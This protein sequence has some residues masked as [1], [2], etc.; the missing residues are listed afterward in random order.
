MGTTEPRVAVYGR[1]EDGH[2]VNLGD[3]PTSTYRIDAQKLLNKFMG[4]DPPPEP[5]KAEVKE[6]KT[7]E[8]KPKAKSRG[9]YKKK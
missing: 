4:L 9:K 1:D 2:R 8:S 3:V 7:K 6:S 5:K